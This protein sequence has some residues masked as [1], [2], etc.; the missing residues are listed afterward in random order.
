MASNLRSFGMA[1]VSCAICVCARAQFIG[2]LSAVRLIVCLC[3]FLGSA[4]FVRFT[5][6]YYALVC[7]VS[8]WL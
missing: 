5:T 2:F 3:I 1:F 4:P 6:K 7:V 8:R